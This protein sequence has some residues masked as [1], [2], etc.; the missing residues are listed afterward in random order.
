MS[1]EKF[2]NKTDLVSTTITL[3]A[4]LK[5]IYLCYL[6]IKIFFT[7]FLQPLYNQPSDADIYHENRRK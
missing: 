2:A 1:L 3:M 4:L 6:K 7:Y 5:L